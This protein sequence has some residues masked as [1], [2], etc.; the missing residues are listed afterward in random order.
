M[1]PLFIYIL[2]WCI[3]ESAE[4][5]IPHATSNWTGIMAGFALFYGVC[6]G[7]AYYLWKRGIFIKL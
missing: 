4:R 1:N 6:Y 2:Q 3:M 5:F 7:T